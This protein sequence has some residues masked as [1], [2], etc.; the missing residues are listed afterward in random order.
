MITIDVKIANKITKKIDNQRRKRILYEVKKEKIL[1]AV[2][3]IEKTKTQAVKY[4]LGFDENKD[5]NTI[6]FEFKKE[7]YIKIS[8]VSFHITDDVYK[9]IKRLQENL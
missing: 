9:E 3:L 6:T 8:Q 2:E 7:K 5:L 4:F 1:E